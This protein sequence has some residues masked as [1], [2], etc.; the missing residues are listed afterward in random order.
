MKK[1]ILSLILACSLLLP[2]AFAGL[3]EATALPFE[4][5]FETGYNADGSDAVPQL[6][7]KWSYVD[8][9]ADKDGFLQVHR[10]GNNS[11]LRLGANRTQSTAASGSDPLIEMGA[12]GIDLQGKTEISFRLKYATATQDQ[13]KVSV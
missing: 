5:D 1:T 13:F 3:A 10:E 8:A 6:W 7:K 2:A 4:D 11:F 12:D 9:K